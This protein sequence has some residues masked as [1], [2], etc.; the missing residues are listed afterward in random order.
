VG[1]SIRPEFF[2]LIAS[3]GWAANGILVRKGARYSGVTGAVLLSFVSNVC[4]LWVISGWTFPEG[5]YRS[6]ALFYFV[7]G[8]LI[9]PALVR[10]LHYTGI[11]R[12]GASRAEP[13]RSVTP[14]FA[15]AIAFIALD[16]RPGIVVYTAIFLTITGM[17]LISYRRE[18]EAQWKTSDLLFPLS[19]AFLA[20]I[21]QNIRKA[22]L[23]ILPNPYVAAAFTA[24]TSL[25][26]FL[27]TLFLSGQGRSLG[28]N[29]SS[30]PFYGAAALIATASQIL[31]FI[32]LSRAEV[33]V[34]VTLTSTS[35]LFTVALSSLFLKDLEKITA[36]VIVGAFLLV[37]GIVLIANR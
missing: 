3:V 27:P 35:P 5:F 25:I 14:L 33:S 17:S 6:P 4:F 13:I 29:R 28:I 16:E 23:I 8:G 11:S 22:G 26:I 32:A 30:F 9:Q 31:S 1:W 19:A 18:G 24:T 12:L 37:A 20:A 2:A 7:L 36:K 10:T 21:S 34:I 15:T